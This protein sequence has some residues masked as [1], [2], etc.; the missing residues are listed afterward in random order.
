M[1]KKTFKNLIIVLV[2][3]LTTSL[4]AF[5]QSYEVYDGKE[6]SV[7][8]TVRN[9]VAEDVKFASIGD[10]TWSDF[11]VIETQN[12]NGESDNG[13]L[14]TF[15]VIDGNIDGYQIDYYENGYIWV[16]NI[17]D[18]LEQVGEGWRLTRRK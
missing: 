14:F 9:Q 5:S 13:T 16:F 15:Y 1:E 18:D 11:E 8:F 12:W 6:F 4:S 17:D 10:K 3:A 2:V 7:M